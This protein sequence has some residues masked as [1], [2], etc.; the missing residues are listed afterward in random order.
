MNSLKNI[1][2]YPK[3]LFTIL[4]LSGCFYQMSQITDQYLSYIAMTNV[5]YN[6]SPETTLPGLTICYQLPDDDKMIENSK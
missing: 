6:L 5:D 3:I 4:C 2:T 1:R